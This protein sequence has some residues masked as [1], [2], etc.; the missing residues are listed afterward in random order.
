M[1]IEFVASSRATNYV[2][3]WKIR[4][5]E[6]D[7]GDWILYLPIVLRHRQIGTSKDPERSAGV[8][9]DLILI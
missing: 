6:P 3:C 2:K 1:R 4:F 5:E 9:P 8:D 7:R